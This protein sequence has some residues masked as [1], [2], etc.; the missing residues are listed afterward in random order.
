MGVITWYS[1]SDYL[2]TLEDTP[3]MLRAAD[4]QAVSAS[5]TR[6]MRLSVSV[7]DE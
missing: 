2:T 4:K 6:F 1:G 3:T 5:S 7:A